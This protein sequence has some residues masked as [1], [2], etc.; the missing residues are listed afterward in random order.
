MWCSLHSYD[1]V[2]ETGSTVSCPKRK[3]K[4]ATWCEDLK[5]WKICCL[6]RRKKKGASQRRS[7]AQGLLKAA[8]NAPKYNSKMQSNM[9]LLLFLQLPSWI[10]NKHNNYTKILLIIIQYEYIKY[11]YVYTSY[12]QVLFVFKLIQPTYASHVTFIHCVLFA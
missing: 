7:T 11:T 9:F 6:H 1:G 2:L 12:F 3:L 4:E 5:C 10:L 8:L